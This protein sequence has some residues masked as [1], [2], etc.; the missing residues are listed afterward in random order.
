MNKKRGNILFKSKHAQVTIFILIAV[1]IVAAVIIFFTVTDAG[2]KVVNTIIGAPIQVDQQMKNCIENNKNMQTNLKL[3]ES[4]G[5]SLN[6]KNYLLYNNSKIEY[7]CYTNEYYQSCVMQKPLLIQD[8]KKEIESYSKTEIVNC[9]N[10]IKSDLESRGYTTSVGQLNFSVEIGAKDIIYNI[11]YP[12]TVQK[13]E[14]NRY[15]NFNIK[16]PSSLY[17]LVMISTS[18]LNYEARYG[19]T[20]PM[21]FMGLYPDVRVNKQKQSDGSKIYILS[22]RQ[23]NELFQF[24]T[25]SIVLPP[26][27]FAK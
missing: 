10:L 19:D 11:K 20:D 16:K 18:I 15:E 23:S 27:Y 17:Q 4:Q 13:Q 26:G 8:I 14:T 24:A 1:V 25:R 3:I 22:D 5:G 9:M 12:I 21:T 6:P 2:K 7:L